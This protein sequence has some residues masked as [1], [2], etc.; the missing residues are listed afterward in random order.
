MPY[1]DKQQR[2]EKGLCTQCPNP[3]R[4]PYN[5]CDKCL[6]TDRRTAKIRQAK[7]RQKRIRKNL[8]YKCGGKLHKDAD[9]GRISCIN[10]REAG[11]WNYYLR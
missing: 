2:P 6:A 1:K 9:N 4:L 11:K 10:C 8:C 5:R 7:L 3:V